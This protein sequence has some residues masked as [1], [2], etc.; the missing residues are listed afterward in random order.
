MGKREMDTMRPGHLDIR[1]NSRKAWNLYDG[2]RNNNNNNN[3]DRN[4]KHKVQQAINGQQLVSLPPNMELFNHQVAGHMQDGVNL[5][6][7]KFL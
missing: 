4:G 2:E 7:M 3:A 5:G 1:P 6:E